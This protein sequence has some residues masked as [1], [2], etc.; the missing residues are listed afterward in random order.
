MPYSRSLLQASWLPPSY[1]KTKGKPA[2]IS[3]HQVNAL[4]MIQ[5]PVVTDAPA[6]LTSSQVQ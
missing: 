4:E 5:A 6:Q 3:I 2:P 1:D